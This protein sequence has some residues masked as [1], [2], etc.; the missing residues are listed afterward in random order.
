MQTTIVPK[1]Q[2]AAAQALGSQQGAVIA[3]DPKTGAVLAMVTSP[4][5]DPNTIASHDIDAA[6]K[7]YDTLAK[8]PNRPLAN[9]AA[10]EIYPPGSTF[11]LVTAAAALA[12]GKS[13]DT[14]VDAPD[15]L[16]LPGTNTFLPNDSNCGGTP[17]HDAPGPGG[18]LQHGVRQPRA[19]ARSRPSC[20]S[21]RPSSGSTNG[22]C[23]SSAA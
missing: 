7:A 18:L 3:L 17:N 10:R 16:R 4:A 12:D 11:K 9:R 6:G 15:R 21:R 22:T 2:Q 8:D 1:I 13:P 19:G 20:V 23:P 5:Y 14:Q